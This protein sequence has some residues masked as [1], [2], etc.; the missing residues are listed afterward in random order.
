MTAYKIRTYHRDSHEEGS[1]CPMCGAPFDG[2][3]YEI[4]ANGSTEDGGFCSRSCAEK[5]VA[6]WKAA[7]AMSR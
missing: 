7:E 4:L 2:K 1:E 5:R 3:A 6:K